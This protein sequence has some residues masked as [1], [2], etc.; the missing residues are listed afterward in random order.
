MSP[1][2]DN[3]T[4]ESSPKENE[5]NSSGKHRPGSESSDEIPDIYKDLQIV[6]TNANYRII[7]IC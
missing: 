3:T 6:C 2:Q 1:E 7:I 5:D 4:N